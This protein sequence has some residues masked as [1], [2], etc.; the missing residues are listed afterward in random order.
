MSVNPGIQFPD[1]MATLDF[2][3][4]IRQTH[5]FVNRKSENFIRQFSVRAL[6]RSAAKQKRV[7]LFSVRAR[8]K[9]NVDEPHRIKAAV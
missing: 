4:I 3:V 8:R 5:V 1:V 9:V 6:A 2:D 7:G